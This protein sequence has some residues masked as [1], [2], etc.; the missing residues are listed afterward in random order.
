[1]NPLQIPRDN[2][3]LVLR[4]PKDLHGFF[5]CVGVVGRCRCPNP[6]VVQGSVAFLFLESDNSFPLSGYLFLLQVDVTASSI[7]ELERQ[8]EKL[9]KV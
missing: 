3:S 5:Y 7:P 4:K 9:S 1:M 2:C 8:I 6:F